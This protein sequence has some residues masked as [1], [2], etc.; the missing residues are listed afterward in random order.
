MLH[1]NAAGVTARCPLDPLAQ[2]K[3][4][5]GLDARASRA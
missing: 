4:V 3:V 2:I 1:A 5:P